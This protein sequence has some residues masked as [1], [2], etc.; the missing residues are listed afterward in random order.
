MCEKNGITLS[1]NLQQKHQAQYDHFKDLKDADFD[2]YMKHQ[3]KD[4]EEDVAVFTKQAKAANNEQVRDFAAKT[5]P[6]LQEHLKMVSATAAK[7][8]AD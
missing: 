1:K 7:V 2:A 5:L 8:G 6:V 4:H 3:V